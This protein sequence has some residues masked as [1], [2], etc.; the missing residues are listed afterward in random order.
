MSQ[1]MVVGW[2]EKDMKKRLKSS[3]N[4]CAC[5][6]LRASKVNRTVTSCAVV[7]DLTNLGP[8]VMKKLIKSSFA[9][10]ALA[11]GVRVVTSSD[12]KDLWPYDRMVATTW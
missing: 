5:A 10:I 4:C 7:M 9:I 6:C 8:Q 12:R 2:T 1:V 11:L 3:A